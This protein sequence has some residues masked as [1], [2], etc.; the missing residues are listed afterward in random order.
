MGDILQHLRH[1]QERSGYNE[2]HAMKILSLNEG[3]AEVH[4]P[5][6][7]NIL[8]PLGNVHG[9][10][11]FT[12][13]DV[14]AGSAAATRGRVGVTL[15]SSIQYLRPGHGDGEALIAKT[16]EMK[17]GRTTAVYQVEVM[18]GA[19]KIAEGTFTMYYT[20]VDTGNL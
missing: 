19:R 10:A 1:S 15:S 11:I 9:G 18:Q 13:C 4:M 20:G 12:L 17:A 3:Y 7:E 16:R 14:A 2:F 6:C 8:N 5:V